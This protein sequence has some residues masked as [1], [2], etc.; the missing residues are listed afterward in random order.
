MPLY[1]F[2]NQDGEFEDFF[3][4][5][6]EVP[7]LGDVVEL[8]GKKWTRVFT[9]PNAAI[10]ITSDPYS[11]K[12]FNKRLDGKNITIGDMWDASKEASEK[13]AAKEGVDPIKKEYYDSYAKKRHGVKHQNEK[14]EIFEKTKKDLG[15]KI[16][17]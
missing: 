13:R 16:D 12:D 8:D 2:T 1:S 9:K 6:K 17:L 11:A 5:M 15:I 7:K 14:K 3:F 4:T 10:A